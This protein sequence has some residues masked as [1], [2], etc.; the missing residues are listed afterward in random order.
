MQEEGTL[1]DH[2]RRRRSYKNI[3]G[4][5]NRVGGDN[6]VAFTFDNGRVSGDA[7][8]AGTVTASV[9]NRDVGNTSSWI[10]VACRTFVPRQLLSLPLKNDQDPGEKETEINKTNKGRCATS[11]GS[12]FNRSHYSLL[13][14]ILPTETLLKP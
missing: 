4:G 11:K 9:T 8:G 14:A 10:L 2:H 1:V 5:K 13:Q 6:D 3:S 7:A 12:L